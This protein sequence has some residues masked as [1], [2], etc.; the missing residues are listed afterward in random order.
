[1]I[2]CPVCGSIFSRHD[3]MQRH[4]RQKH[5]PDQFVP[6]TEEKPQKQG[7]DQFVPPTEETPHSRPYE[8]Q[9]PCTVVISGPSGSGKSVLTKD[10]LCQRSIQPSPQRIIWCYGQYQPL[11]DAIQRQLPYVEF[12]KGI[13]EFLEHESFLDTSVRNCIVLD[14]LM[15]DAKKNDKISR[16]FSIGSHHRNLT[17]LYLTQNVFPQGKACRDVALNTKYLVLFNNPVD[18]AQVLNLARRIYPNN[19]QFF[20]N[21]Y[22]RAI[23]QC[24]GYLIIDMRANTSEQERLKPNAL[25]YAEHENKTP[26]RKPEEAD[27]NEGPT[28]KRKLDPSCDCCGAIYVST[29]QLKNH[30]NECY[31]M[32]SCGECGKVFETQEDVDTH[33]ELMHDDT[34]S[35]DEWET[36][37]Q[38]ANK[39]LYF[40]W[41]RS[42]VRKTWDDKVQEAEDDL[43]SE[44]KAINSL[45]PNIQKT[46]RQT[47][48]DLLIDITNM[49]KD[50]LYQTLMRT[51][52]TCVKNNKLNTESA[53]RCAVKMH[54][55]EINNLFMPPRDE[56]ETEDTGDEEYSDESDIED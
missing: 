7:P 54:K 53:I 4:R 31:K 47:L 44:N 14:D 43:G 5:G 38:W 32:P 52:E 16:L 17:V 27:I 9:H 42:T 3:A 21:T 22:Q 8:F 6:P 24:Y 55:D 37:L 48:T 26:K 28:Q 18:R 50:V 41:I 33:T 36:D 34:D 15:G 23:E 56:S 51:A 35:L 12:V 45:L 46:T 40:K 29:S 39:D 20:M 30:E 11:Y 25:G 19:S 1:M 10:I 49:K 13:P 2:P